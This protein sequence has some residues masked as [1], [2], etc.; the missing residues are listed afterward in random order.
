[1][2]KILS[3][4][5]T[6]TL[7]GTST[8]SLVAC[9]TSQKYTKDELEHL[10]KENQINTKDGILEWIAP[11]EKPFNQIDNNKYYFVVWRGDDNADW[12]IVKFQNNTSDWI[13]IDNSKNS[14]L[15]KRNWIP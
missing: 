13:K 11:Q 1:M 12:R 4:L 7:I 3:L 9:N 6:I 15:K 2:K 14:K 5:G 8:T 10:K